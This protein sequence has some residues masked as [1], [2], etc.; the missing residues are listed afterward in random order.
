MRTFVDGQ[1]FPIR[2]LRQQ[3]R[4][5]RIKHHEKVD[6]LRKAATWTEVDGRT[7]A[8]FADGGQWFRVSAKK[9]DE[10]V[11]QHPNATPINP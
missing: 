1:E 9:L 5:E 11:R 10:F 3:R 6:A 7:I 4:E 2:S 8:S